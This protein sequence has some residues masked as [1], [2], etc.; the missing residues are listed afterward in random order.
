MSLKNKKSYYN[1]LF[2]AV[3]YSRQNYELVDSGFVFLTKILL[4]D[5]SNSTLEVSQPDVAGWCVCKGL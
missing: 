3:A 5:A 2:F 4:P 1:A